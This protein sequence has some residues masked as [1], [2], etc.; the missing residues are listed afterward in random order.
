MC[1]M[2]GHI[3]YFWS[4]ELLVKLINKCLHYHNIF[5]W[6]H[7]C[8]FF[9]IL[10]CGSQLTFS[11]FLKWMS[12]VHYTIWDNYVNMKVDCRAHC[13]GGIMPFL[14]RGENIWKI[15]TTTYHTFPVWKSMFIW[16]KI[17]HCIYVHV[18]CCYIYMMSIRYYSIFISLIN[19][20]FQFTWSS[21][22]VI[23]TL[24]F[25]FVEVRISTW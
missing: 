19:M 10:H 5:P 3:L 11:F 1:Q 9:F 2:K 24:T 15:W 7:F 6:I 21:V 8:V 18:W 14:I 4:V 12:D 16:W 17:T 20:T 25:Q 23:L 13:M 22:V